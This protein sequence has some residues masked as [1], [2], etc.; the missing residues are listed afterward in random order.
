MYNFEQSTGKLNQF[1]MGVHFTDFG[2]FRAPYLLHLPY[3]YHLI[4]HALAVGFYIGTYTYIP[5]QCSDA[6][7]ERLYLPGT[8]IVTCGIFFT[9]YN[10]LRC[11]VRLSYSACRFSL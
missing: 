1:I 7:C 9:R 10:T 6:G 3:L 2:A 11:A 5:P 4:R 8:L